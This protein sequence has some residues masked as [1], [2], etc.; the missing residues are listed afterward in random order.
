[1]RK[2][3]F[4][5][6]GLWMCTGTTRASEP[7]VEEKALAS[8]LEGDID[9]ALALL[10][11]AAET[12]PSLQWVAGRVALNHEE[13]TEAWRLFDEDEPAGLW[14]RIDVSMATGDA[15]AAAPAALAEMDAAMSGGH[16]EALAE[17]LLE[18]AGRRAGRDPDGAAAML[19]VVLDLGVPEDLRVRA[20][21]ALFAMDGAAG[22]RRVVAAARRRVAADPE[23][24]RSALV[25]GEYLAE[26]S[27]LAAFRWLS[28]TVERAERSDALRAARAIIPLAVPD[29]DKVRV[30]DGLAERFPR[31]REV[32][33]AR[34]E[35]A[36]TIVGADEQTGG[37]ALAALIDDPAVG[38]EAFERY[39]ET[40][41]D[42]ALRR[43]RWLALAA[44][45]GISARGE[46]ARREARAALV[47]IVSSYP[48][49]DERRKAARD[50]LGNADGQSIPEILYWALE[51][52]DER[53]AGLWD[54]AERFPGDGPWCGE[55][56]ARLVEA[57]AS[58]QQAGAY[59]DM[60]AA[61]SGVEPESLLAFAGEREV[62][63]AESGVDG[64]D[65]IAGGGTELSVAEHRV[66]PEALF[67]AAGGD[68]LDVA[69]DAFLIEPDTSFGVELEAESLRRYHLEPRTMA[70]LLS[71]T[72]RLKD[73]QTSTLVI[74]EPLEIQGVLQG[75][76]VAIAVFQDHAP[77]P[78][79]RVVILDG[80]GEDIELATG[81]DG[82]LCARGLHGDVRMMAEN[83][84]ALGFLVLPGATQVADVV[85]QFDLRLWDR[86]V[87]EQ[88]RK[89]QVQVFGTR[90][91]GG[92]LGPVTV[93]SST[94]GG[95]PLDATVVDLAGGEATVELWLQGGGTVQLERGEE[96]LLTRDVPATPRLE[97]DTIALALSPATPS[98]GDELHVSVFDTGPRSPDGKDSKVTI[99]TPW[100]T[101]TWA[102][103]MT[104]TSE[105]FTVSLVP[106]AVNDVVEILVEIAGH[107]ARF[108]VAV[109][110]PGAVSPPD[111]GP[112]VG[113][114]QVVSWQPDGG[115]WL[116]VRPDSRSGF[117]W[118]APS[119]PLLFDD[120]GLYW[121][122]SW[123][124]GT[125][126]V[127]VPVRVP[128]RGA[129]VDSRG[130]WQGE[131]PV[132]V[133]DTAARVE[134]ARVVRPGERV[135]GPMATGARFGWSVAGSPAGLTIP[136]TGRGRP[137]LAIT[138]TLRRGATSALTIGPDLPMG[139]RVWAFIHDASDVPGMTS[140]SLLQRF[141]A[142]EAGHPAC[143]RH[144]S[145]TVGAPIDH[146]LLEE[147]QR[148]AEQREARM[149]PLDQ[150]WQ[151]EMS[152][153]APPPLP[154]STL[155]FT[156]GVAAAG[157]GGG[158]QRAVRKAAPASSAT[159]GY[160]AKA[161]AVLDDGGPGKWNVTVPSWITM[162]DV[163]V[164]A[165]TPDGR[166]VAASR[167]FSVEGPAPVQRTLE[168]PPGLPVAWDGSATSLF[169]AALSLPVDARR[170][171]LAALVPAGVADAG[172]ALRAALSVA[173]RQGIGAALA[174]TMTLA[175]P[176]P[177]DNALSRL[178]GLP[179]QQ[180]AARIEAALEAAATEPERTRAVAE[181]LLKE[182][183]IEPWVRARAGLALWATGDRNGAIA[184]LKGDDFLLAAVRAAVTGVPEPAHVSAWWLVARSDAANPYDRAIA[185]HALATA[186]G[187]PAEQVA[188]A[189]TPE[190]LP[191]V[192]TP[193]LACH[194]GL[195][196]ARGAWVS[197]SAARI[198]IGEV[199]R[200][201]AL[202]DVPV[203]VT[204]RP[205]ATPS[206]VRCPMAPPWSASKEWIDLA[207]S[208]SS[209]KVTCVIR[210]ES[211]GPAE[212]A[213]S[214]FGPSGERLGRATTRVTVEPARASTA[215]DT[216]SPD[217]RYALGI[218]L[219]REGSQ[220]GITLLSSLLTAEWLRPDAVAGASR[221]C[222]EGAR[223]GTDAMGLVAAFEAYR[224]RAAEGELDLATAAKV[225][226]AYAETGAPRRAVAA[227]R[228][229][230]DARFQEEL[231]AIRRIQES[232]YAMSALKLLQILI[233]RYPEVP[234]VQTARY[235]APSVILQLAEG[236]GDRYGYTRAS[237][238]HTAAA[239]LARFLLVHPDAGQAPEAATLLMD[240]LQQLRDP[241][242]EQ[243]L[244]G[245]LADHYRQFPAAWRLSV[246]DARARFARGKFDD[247]AA[248]LEA[249]ERTPE[250]AETLALE[251][252]RVYEAQ[253][254][255]DEALEMY[256]SAP[257]S[258]EARARKQWLERL[259]LELPESIV[260]YPGDRMEIRAF[261][262][263]GTEIELTAYRIS[264]EHLL[265][266][267]GGRL[268]GSP[269]RVDGFQ[270]ERTKHVV[271]GSDGNIPLPR[272]AGGAYLLT[273][274]LGNGTYR[275]ILLKT[276]GELDVRAGDDGNTLV[277]LLD[278]RGRPVSD[279]KLWFFD[280]G[281]LVDTARTDRLGACHVPFGN[282]EV[283]VLARWG[284]T[285]AWW[286]PGEV[287]VP[288]DGWLDTDVNEW[289]APR[290][291]V[292]NQD[293]LE[294][295]MAGYNS[296]FNQQGAAQV[297]AKAL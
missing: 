128:A 29:P 246:A 112:V 85:E 271:V 83:D 124:E 75:D 7:S 288:G 232:G 153:P 205:L 268:D 1:M 237:L 121:L 275:T 145:V 70:P 61:A 167:R 88:G 189:E 117:R 84:G 31:D 213:I 8:V 261:L 44:Q 212:I 195:S 251:L 22:R 192:V 131:H 242:R 165:A 98:I 113:L 263:Q 111:V 231:G 45:E 87:P 197:R 27:P 276:D 223:Q 105:T 295:N 67:R 118:I 204:I 54:L 134:T 82:A 141:W 154:E 208:W 178:R 269:V 221:M 86:A 252:G 95:E 216:L 183:E 16:R 180:R 76:A 126:S 207:P 122:S 81:E 297:Q 103:L 185:I 163:V 238:R 290:R 20:E 266:K 283:R 146:A 186:T 201:P 173:P 227:A 114:G 187:T 243:S 249:L 279:A 23:D 119:T 247:A 37:M 220:A 286:D 191:M 144:A 51:D 168:A 79:A 149:I 132:L 202:R 6:I 159:P 210:A 64:L 277:H 92:L 89:V 14:G 211:E 175:A 281:G 143:S 254:K 104:E 3:L 209:R 225:A 171:A 125:G 265:L 139:T 170:H 66:D 101:R 78:G 60:C 93:R 184:A 11:E 97:S 21:N 30:L 49:G 109:Q 28:R 138:G 235:L 199:D 17:R 255:A 152:A 285:Y 26:T 57:G 100:E 50:A 62:L 130:R 206:R 91:D 294:Q 39:A 32:A 219:A 280:A 58:R 256:G 240:T 150:A 162:A 230:L 236:D 158:R 224:E 284:R 257:D 193:P 292:K 142:G 264:L 190:E 274:G 72:T 181:R 215:E 259:D 65:V 46:H 250:S 174:A 245:P 110:P 135:P 273:L 129:P 177:A 41:R 33:R 196:F 38:P 248:I 258:E 71:V 179:D 5:L 291:A 287:A 176:P 69:L 244:A 214:W 234:T 48:E 267:N 15:G 241:E 203:T 160:D 35:L 4:L 90:P 102:R 52:D 194:H 270:P 133:A 172:P 116:R 55:L 226:H 96:L 137:E 217:E 12:D 123:H 99:T 42:P 272:L 140:P 157:Y 10:E 40:T 147:E 24:P 25:V 164:V 166:W 161:I 198:Q 115:T 200:V 188:F 151:R 36:S 262:R 289:E 34:L 239:G 218:A 47:A 43:E 233:Q 253:G 94:A 229:V 59:G 156:G 68:P 228:V 77:V 293:L 282:G 127:E 73:L 19:E 107:E 120:P 106:A 169:D 9:T 2:C 80:A 222:L 74:T 56:A 296:L 13:Y 148:N 63:V 108:E 18:W 136:R 155:D 278:D 53:W 182:P 260:L